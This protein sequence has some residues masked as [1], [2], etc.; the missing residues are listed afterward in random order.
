MGRVPKGSVLIVESLDRLSRDQVRPALQ[1]L[2]ALQDHGITIVTLQPEREYPP[3]GTDALALIEPLIVFARAHEESSMKSHRRKDGWNQA[4]Q[5]AR[6]QARGREQ[7]Q[8]GGKALLRTCPAWLEVT[9]EGAFR[10]LDKPAAA[11]RR[12]YALAREGMGTQRIAARLTEE[13]FPPIGSGKRWIKRYVHK[14]L[15][16]PAAMGA[17]QPRRIERGRRQGRRS[18]PDGD[19][20]QGHYPPVLTEAEWREAQAALHA[21]AD[22]RGAGRV[23]E[24]EP[25]LFTSLCRCALSGETLHLLRITAP[26]R[27]GVQKKHTYLAPCPEAR[28]NGRRLG[29]DYPT[30]ESAIL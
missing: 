5:R 28:G 12:I 13:G 9:E 6:L 27:K 8:P 24:G 26:L 10:V 16:E 29:V 17:Y 18:V 11:V 19:P 1:L 14:I 30:F 4:K 22:R 2:F 25:N 15:S 7:D 23:G 20:I 21:R 3:D